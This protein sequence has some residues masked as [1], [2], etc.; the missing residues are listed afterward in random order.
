MQVVSYVRSTLWSLAKLAASKRRWSASV[1]DTPK[2]KTVVLN[3]KHGRANV[4]GT[5]ARYHRQDESGR[6]GHWLLQTATD[7]PIG[8]EVASASDRGGTCQAFG[9]ANDAR[10]AA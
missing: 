2:A 3:L 9:G 8:A 6:L 1:V 7:A 4:V 10:R 5:K